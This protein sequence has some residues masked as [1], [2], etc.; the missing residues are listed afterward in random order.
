MNVFV[1]TNVLLDVL[2]DREEFI[3]DSARVWALC[4]REAL[5]GYVSAISYNNCHY[6]IGRLEN[7]STAGRAIRLILDTFRT[8]PLDERII[9]K[10]LDASFA[11]FEDAIQYYSAIHAG[12]DYLITRNPK[13][14]PKRT[15]L[16]IMMP[17]EFVGLALDLDGSG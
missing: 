11:D 10:A 15:D 16:P 5:E 2:L 6:L 14:F 8:V 1:D 17:D 9:H 12:A 3:E 7:K 4:E 13:D